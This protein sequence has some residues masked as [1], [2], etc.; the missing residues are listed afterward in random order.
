MRPPPHPTPESSSK[1]L[2]AESS[3]F[4]KRMHKVVGDIQLSIP[5]RKYIHILCESIDLSSDI[6]DIF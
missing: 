4:A 3:F 2:Y 1:N 5:H 6:N